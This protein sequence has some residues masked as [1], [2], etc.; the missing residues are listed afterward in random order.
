MYRQ[1]MPKLWPIINLLGINL[2]PTVLVFLS[3]IPVYKALT[4]GG[5]VRLLTLAGFAVCAFA[6]LMELLA[7][8]QM[9]RYKNRPQPKS[10]YIAEGV[11]LWCRHPNYLG[12]VLFWWGVWLMQASVVP[13][14]WTVAGALLITLLFVFVSIPM[15]EKHVLE[16]RPEYAEYIKNVPMILPIGMLR[17]DGLNDMQPLQ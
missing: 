14:F 3:M 1:N 2:M 17:K 15:M 12:E 10:P 7:D 11:W 5:P 4:S 8:I 6:I 16:G 9:D 13:I